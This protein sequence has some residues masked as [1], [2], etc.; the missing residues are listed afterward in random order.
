MIIIRTLISITGW[1]LVA[2]GCI[3]FFYKL[4]LIVSYPLEYNSSE[5][6]FSELLRG[7]IA[8]L[9]GAALVLAVLKIKLNKEAKEKTV[10]HVGYMKSRKEF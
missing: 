1:I 2:C 5:M 7:G 3:D 9:T 8:L 4:Y 10:S 6:I